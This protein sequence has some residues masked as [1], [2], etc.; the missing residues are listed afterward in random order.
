MRAHPAY[1]GLEKQI[2]DMMREEGGH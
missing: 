1:A 2:L